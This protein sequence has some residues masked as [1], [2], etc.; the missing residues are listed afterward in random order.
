MRLLLIALATVLLAACSKPPEPQAA[1]EVK[2][3]APANA[4]TAHKST[5]FD[6][7]LKTE[8][9]ARGVEKTLKDADDKRR[10]ELEKMGG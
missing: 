9:K 7:M 10:K 1:S 5:P 4:A 8:D 2:S 6:T 3:G